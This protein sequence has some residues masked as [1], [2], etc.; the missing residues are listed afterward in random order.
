M[1][2]GITF[3]GSIA[4]LNMLHMLGSEGH[5]HEPML[6]RCAYVW[7]SS[8]LHTIKVFSWS[9]MTQRPPVASWCPAAPL[10]WTVSHKNTL[11]LFSLAVRER[12]APL[13]YITHFS[14][15]RTHNWNNKSKIKILRRV[16]KSACADSWI[17][18]MLREGVFIARAYATCPSH[19]SPKGLFDSLSLSLSHSFSTSWS[20]GRTLSH[21]PDHENN[22]SKRFTELRVL[23]YWNTY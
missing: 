15:A 10:V 13:W 5:L 6:C 3:A 9:G 18:W 2:H 17:A 12:I 7:L 16:K 19:P 1:P 20:Y 23:I 22:V 11:C 4:T 21:L 8:Q 14:Q